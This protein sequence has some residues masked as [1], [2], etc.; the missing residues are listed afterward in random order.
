MFTPLA[1]L[2]TQILTSAL[3]L[4]PLIVGV[5]L[6]LGGAV[7]ALGNHQRGKEAVI[8]ALLGGAIMVTSQAV[9]ASVHA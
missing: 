5:A 6:L 4:V 9:G 7:L 2:V 1:T 3:T 8:C